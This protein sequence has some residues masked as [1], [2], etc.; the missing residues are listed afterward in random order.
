M[1]ATAET[2][3]PDAAYEQ[4]A[5]R[6]AEL[7]NEKR[8][9]LDRLAKFETPIMTLRAEWQQEACARVADALRNGIFDWDKMG[10]DPKEQAANIATIVG[11]DIR[12]E[13]GPTEETAA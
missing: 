1:T 11:N 3:A 7:E 12:R 5:E 13:A 8:E 6:N 2:Q 4:L 10:G 9:L